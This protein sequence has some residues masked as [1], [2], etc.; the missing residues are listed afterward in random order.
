MIDVATKVAHLSRADSYPFPAATVEVVETHM[1]W[2]FL[3]GDFVYKMKKPIAL[4]FVDFRT[5]SA[6]K[7]FCDQ[8]LRLNRRLAPSVYLDVVPLISDDSGHL[9]LEGR[10]EAGTE[11]VEWL[12]KMRRLPEAMMLDQAIA[13]GTVTTADAQRVARRLA[14]FYRD[15]KPVALTTQDYRLKLRDEIE[16]HFRVLAAPDFDLPAPVLTILKVS[17]L[18]FLDNNRALFDTRVAE[19]YIVEAHGDLRPEHICLLAEPVIID[20]LEFDRA[21]RTKDTVHE[22]AFLAMECE[23]AGAAFIGQQVF[24]TYSR[25]TGDRPPAALINFYKLLEA[26]VRARLA[27]L[28]I[29]DHPVEVH[30]HWLQRA[31]IYLNLAEN[32]R[33]ALSIGQEAPEA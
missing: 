8:S 24:A 1:S 20:C 33:Q 12:E 22:L 5:L 29:R 32:Y 30:A 18:D 27:A 6:R 7:Y 4:P 9:R 2:V 19:G 16:T 10:A 26:I 21:V 14:V 13:R 31:G 25:E 15:A 28:H 17:L 11:T 23:L 3:V